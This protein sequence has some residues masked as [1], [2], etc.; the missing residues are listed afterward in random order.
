MNQSLLLR[1]DRVRL[2]RLACA[3]SLALAISASAGVSYAFP[4]HKE[5]QVPGSGPSGWA[6]RR[7]GGEGI[8]YSGGAGDTGMKCTVCHVDNHQQQG[9]V[10]V[11]VSPSPAWQTV[12]S[13][14]AYQPGQTYT[15]TVKLANEHL[16][17][18]T[19]NNGMTLT[20]ED[21]AG[22]VA[23]VFE[24]DVGGRSDSSAC[25]AGIA[26]DP[27]TGDPAASQTTTILGTCRAVLSVAHPNA[28]K[29]RVSW[30]F[31][32]TAPKTGTGALTVFVGAVDGDTSGTSSLN[33][34]VAHAAVTL[35]EGA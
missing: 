27:L 29:A 31:K 10:S 2:A 15:I 26:T 12:K 28:G 7:P 16:G 5:W 21:A 32:W 20:I 35:E 18:G 25:K 8:Y 1:R 24:P 34:D 19:D 3:A 14:S 30:N 17:D 11:T 22:K 33:D 13:A 4:A 6:G 9:K 23:G